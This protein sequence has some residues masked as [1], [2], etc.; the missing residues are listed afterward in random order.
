MNEPV[1]GQGREVIRTIEVFPV[2]LPVLRSFNFASGSGGQ[3]GETITLIYVKIVGSED[4]VGWGECRPVPQWSSETAETAI[5]TIEYYL[6]PVLLGHPVWD[7]YGAHG[8]M[9]AA[10]QAGPTTG[11]PIAKAAIDMALHDLLS[12]RA[13]VPLRQF[14]GGTHE[15]NSIDLSFT[16]TA[17]DKAGVMDQVNGAREDGFRHFNF[18]AAVERKTDLVVAETI[19]S[20]MDEDGFLCADANQGY[21]IAD[22][23]YAAAGF[24]EIGVNVL[25]QPLPADQLLLMRELRRATQIPLAV[26]EA[27]VSPAN[28]F[29]Y[30]RTGLV[31]YLVI[32]VTRSGGIWPSSQQIAIAQEAGLGLLVSGLSDGMLAKLATCQLVSV[33]DFHGPAALN[34]SQ[35]IDDSGLFPTKSSV[36]T[37]GKVTLN[38]EAGIGLVPLITS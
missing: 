36:E 18:K 10:I 1:G 30:A 37:G 25:E 33:F 27:S 3:A 20:L 35:F 21:G 6:K 19:R 23:K 28:F 24:Q 15:R 26:D 13:K 34:G 4:S 38:D 8:K 9:N 32:K 17:H 11:Q 5:S 22:A 16:V 31:D 14:L 12:R 2:Q 7:R 29:E